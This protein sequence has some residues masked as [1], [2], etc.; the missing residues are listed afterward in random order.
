MARLTSTTST[1]S[2]GATSSHAR[3]STRRRFG[4]CAKRWRGRRRAACNHITSAPSSRPLSEDAGGVIRSRGEGPCGAYPG[5]A[6]PSGPRPPDQPRR[7]RCWNALSDA[8]ASTRQSIAGQPQATLV[9][10]GHPL[11]D[12]LVD[13]DA[14]A[15]PRAADARRHAGRREQ[16][17]RRTA[18]MLIALR[19]SIRDGRTTSRHGKPQTISERLQFVWLDEAGG[20]VGG[21]PAPSPRLPSGKR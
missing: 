1:R 14:G 21:G 8:S 12:A 6:K 16:P 7:T 18:C 2:S 11:L 5:A 19:H 15:V 13:L 4:A 17:V 10:P 9:A 20:A 3:G